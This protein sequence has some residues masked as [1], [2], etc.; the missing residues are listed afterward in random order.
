MQAGRQAG[1]LAGWQAGWQAGRQQ[2]CVRTWDGMKVNRNW[3]RQ[4]GHDGIMA[5]KN[6]LMAHMLPF[7]IDWHTDSPVGT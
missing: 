4:A 3:K 2:A 7:E 6:K 1:S 5:D